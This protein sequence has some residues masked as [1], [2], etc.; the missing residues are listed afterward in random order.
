MKPFPTLK[1]ETAQR[2][3][4]ENLIGEH[5]ANKIMKT[6]SESQIE[7]KLVAYCRQQGLLTYKFSSPA[8][9]GVP[10]RVIMGKG[11]VL[12]LELKKRGGRPSALQLHVGVEM[13]NHGIRW[14]WTDTFEGV[15]AVI[16]NFFFGRMRITPRDEI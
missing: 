15:K 16:D 11:K 8:H 14:D 12:F 6:P 7:K 9:R 5:R 2:R 1:N 4:V 10:D 13:R 3:I